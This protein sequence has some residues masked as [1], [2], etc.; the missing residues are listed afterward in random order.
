MANPI[1]IRLGITCVYLVPGPAGYLLIDAG[2]CGKTPVFLG[3]LAAM[4]AGTVSPAHGWPFA[5]RKL[6]I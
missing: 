5:A 2:P 1:M 4:G 3:V 6:P